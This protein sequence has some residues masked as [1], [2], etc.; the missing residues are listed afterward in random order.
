MKKINT[1]A[2]ALLLIVIYA[3]LFIL[4]SILN[5][6]ILDYIFN[7]ALAQLTLSLFLL[8]YNYDL[9]AEQIKALSNK[10]SKSI[11]LFLLSSY[12]F[13]FL[14]LLHLTTSIKFPLL[15]TK[16]SAVS[17]LLII[18]ESI[19]IYFLLHI[20]EFYLYQTIQSSLPE[21]INSKISILI[22]YVVFVI[23]HI[24]LI[25]PFGA[26]ELATN[27]VYYLLIGG[28]LSTMRY[29]KTS[30]LLFAVSAFIMSMLFTLI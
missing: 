30:Y 8:I 24:I 12:V 5:Q 23:L 6:Y 1:H 19:S 28:A 14:F 18:M 2:K 29:T 26:E 27:V 15:F 22:T 10:M 9:F 3:I 17:T 25:L 20:N 4:P 21:S 16:A 13:A 11:L 7:F